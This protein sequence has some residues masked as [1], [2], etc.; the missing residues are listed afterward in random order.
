MKNKHKKH[1]EIARPGMGHYARRE[2]AL[3]GTNCTTIRH[4][5]CR[6]SEA[7]SPHWK[8]A[9]LDADHQGADE[10]EEK[11]RDERSVLTHGAALEY[12]DKLHFQR[13]DFSGA[14]DS[15]RLRPLFNE[16]DALLVNGNHFPAQW[17]VIIADPKKEDS[18]RR[19]LDR[20]TAVQLILLPDGVAELPGFLREHLEAAN[21]ARAL[22]PVLPLSAWGAVVDFF[23]DQLEEAQPRVNGLVLAG[24]RSR[25]MGTDKGLL[26]YHGRPQQDV[27]MDTLELLC[28]KVYLSCRSDQA[29]E[30]AFNHEVLADTFTGLGPMGAILSAFRHEPDAAWL[31]VACDLPLL[32]E[33]TLR[34]LLD[35]R[36]PA[37]VATAFRSPVNE[38]PEPLVALWE[39]K[40]YLLLLQFLAQGHSCPRKVLINSQVHLLDAPAPDALLNVN[41]PEEVDVAMH[42]LGLL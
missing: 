5:S 31:V 39:P 35:H 30:W 9:Y 27:M 14:V 42:K 37:A 34:F 23:K 28:D 13:L 15:Y 16:C 41:T 17:Q 18:L 32:D 8:L 6:L 3:L 21:P 19:K 25:R 24:G 4:L 33:V 7:L 22:P 36:K 2:W 1:E 20:L 10:M 40:S 38:F 12:T 11:G 29:G 26:A